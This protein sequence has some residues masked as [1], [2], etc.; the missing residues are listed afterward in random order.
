MQRKHR[1]QIEKND[2]N[3]FHEAIYY[4]F[5]HSQSSSNKANR[6]SSERMFA[7]RVSWTVKRTSS[8]GCVMCVTTTKD[9]VNECREMNHFQRVWGGETLLFVDGP[10]FLN[11]ESNPEVNAH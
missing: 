6:P 7:L 2:R 9:V 10:I 8:K 1:G 4:L 3:H 11:G 5:I